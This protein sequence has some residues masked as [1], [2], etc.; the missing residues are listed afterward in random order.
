MAFV[1]RVIE[2]SVADRQAAT[3]DEVR[4]LLDAA[5]RVIADSGRVDPPIRAIL[6]EAGLSN[7]A[8]Y[9]HFRGKDELLLALLDEGRGQLVDYLEHRTSRC[10][11]PDEALAE[12]IRGVLAQISEPVAADRT[13]PFVT[14]VTR[15]HQQF[16]AEQEASEAQ[17]I[18]QLATI[19]GAGRAERAPLAYRTVFATLEHHVRRGTPP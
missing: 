12:W 18:D 7:P 5:Y 14:E 17:L 9:R 8:F 10:D 19:L 16:P 2:R 4:Q 15:L 13:R 11:D 3:T 6:A 1:D